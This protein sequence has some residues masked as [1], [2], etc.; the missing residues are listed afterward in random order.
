[1]TD[2][3]TRDPDFE[4]RVRASFD[5]QAFMAHIGAVMTVIRPG[6]CELTLPYGV[7]LTQQDG[8][9]HGGVIGAIADVAGGYAAHSLMSATDRVLT[10]EYKLNIV[11]PGKGRALMARGHVVRPGRTLTATRTDVIADGED[12][13]ILIAIA[14]QTLMRLPGEDAEQGGPP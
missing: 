5:N 7:A 1:M 2:F 6:Y 13:E 11:A 10:V 3:D 14:Q 12:G 8:F 4:Q 9:F